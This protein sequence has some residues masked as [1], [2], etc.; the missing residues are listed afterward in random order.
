MDDLNPGIRRTVAF[1][2]AHG[3]DTCD[4]GDGRTHDH[5]CDRPYPYVT[6]RCDPARLA[7]E[8]DRLR[9]ALTATGVL[10]VNSTRAWD[11]DGD[12]PAGVTIGA[13]YDPCDGV[14]VIDLAGLDDDRLVATARA[15]WA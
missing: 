3:F 10:V 7:A 5:P 15:E 11:H 1:L 9:G 2:R 8:S 14:G 13:S 4:S 12:S 6:M